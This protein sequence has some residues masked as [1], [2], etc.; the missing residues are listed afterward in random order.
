[1]A[2][3]YYENTIND[4]VLRGKKSQLSVTVLKVTHTHLT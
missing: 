4:E 2:T 1:M 3:M